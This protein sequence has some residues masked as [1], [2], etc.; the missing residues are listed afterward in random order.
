MVSERT[1][2][3]IHLAGSR[4]R[5]MRVHSDDVAENTSAAMFRSFLARMAPPGTSQEVLVNTP[6]RYVDAFMELMGANDSAWE[7][8]TFETDCDEMIIVKDIHF[9]SLCEHHLMP[10]IGSAHVAYLPQGRI[11][12]LSKIAR[13]VAACSRGIWTQ[14]H[15]TMNI[16]DF[17]QEKLDPLGVGVVLEAE[18][19]CM[20]VRGVKSNGSKTTTSAMRDAFRDTS[21]GARS[22][23]LGLIK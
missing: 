22:E 14:E 20:S 6:R 17:I 11:A 21:K 7:F 4:E 10:F 15:L 1:D 23:F 2:A 9:C 16:A 5:G 12:G 8:T 13:A 19:T 3:Q 18:H